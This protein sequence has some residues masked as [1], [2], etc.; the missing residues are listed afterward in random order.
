M[1]WLTSFAGYCAPI[2]LIMSP[3]FSY[4]DQ[5]LSMHRNRSSAGF[6]LDIPLIMLVASFFRIFYYPGARFDSALLV[7]SFLMVL[8]QLLLLKIALD[9]RPGP[10]SKGG[11]AAVPFASASQEGFFE[12]RRPYQF[13]QWRSPK[14]YWQFLLYLFII[15]TTLEL[16]LAPF[17]G[18]YAMYS[19]LLGYVG[20]SV[21]ATLPLPQI[22]ANARLRSC[23]G[24][25]V[26]VLA[27]WLAG[28]AMKMFWFFTSTTEIPWAF[29]LCGIFQACCDCFLGIQYLMYGNGDQKLKDEGMPSSMEFLEKKT[30]LPLPVSNGSA[31]ISGRRTPFEKSLQ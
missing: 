7:Q 11:E 8:M 25:R 10:A 5:A 24:F 9:H 6:S 12:R 3:V 23:K 26:S 18:V 22:F 13:W 1:P 19:V 31:T 21:E 29:K 16:I 28:D 17:S 27:S 14:P 15:L 20:L 2:F 4:S 30:V